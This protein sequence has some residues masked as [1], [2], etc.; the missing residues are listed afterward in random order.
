MENNNNLQNKP[1]NDEVKISKKTLYLIGGII[2]A[3]LLITGIYFAFFKNK[4][5]QKEVVNVSASANDSLNKIKKDS[6]NILKDSVQIVKDGNDEDYGEEGS[7]YSEYRLI[8]QSL[9]IASQKLNFGDKVYIDDV[10]STED[11]KLVYL[12]NPEIIKDAT[13]Y[14]ISAAYFINDYRFDEYKKNFSLPPFSDLAPAVKKILLDKNYSDGNRYEITQNADRAKSSVAFGD[15]DG[16]GLRDVAVI[17]DNNEKQISH[18]LIICTNKATKMPYVAFEENYSDKMKINSFSKGA[19]VFM[20]SDE[21]TNSPLNGVILK[22]E[23]VKIA[24]IYDKDLQKFKTYHQ[25]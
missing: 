15:Y 7:P 1:N 16:D 21:F 20:N 14:T 19:S 6:A 2:G 10:K 8:A 18:L 5:D 12:Q 17:Q 23:D 24:L 4:K 11:S 25:E 3:L 13:P 9:P 22:G